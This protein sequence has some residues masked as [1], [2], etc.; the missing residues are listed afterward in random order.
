MG[1]DFSQLPIVVDNSESL[2]EEQVQVLMTQLRVS[3]EHNV[4]IDQGQDVELSTANFDKEL[5][6]IGSQWKG[7]QEQREESAVKQ[8]LDIG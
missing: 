1:D 6:E 2:G 3:M 8:A 5:A 4:K 7:S